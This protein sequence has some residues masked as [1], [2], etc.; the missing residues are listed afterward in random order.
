MLVVKPVSSSSWSFDVQP[1]DVEELT[2]SHSAEDVVVAAAADAAHDD[3]H[4]HDNHDTALYNATAT[5]T[6][7][8]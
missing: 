1:L 3:D 6:L 7:Q 4:H 5:V 8:C 2:H